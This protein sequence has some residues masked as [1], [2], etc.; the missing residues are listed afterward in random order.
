[1]LSIITV[2]GIQI[3]ILRSLLPASQPTQNTNKPT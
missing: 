1:V 3:E 2:F